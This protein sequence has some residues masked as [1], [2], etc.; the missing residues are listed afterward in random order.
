MILWMEGTAR[1]SREGGL[2]GKQ[3]WVG[4]RVPRAREPWRDTEPRA[5]HAPAPASEGSPS[6]FVGRQAKH[7][8]S[9]R[10]LF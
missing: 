2:G 5:E 6:G 1:K 4:S 8:L 10:M 9:Q 3:S 7:V